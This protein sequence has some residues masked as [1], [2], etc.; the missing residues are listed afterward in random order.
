MPEQLPLS[1]YCPSVNL[2]S[3]IK[4]NP[5]AEASAKLVGVLYRNNAALAFGGRLFMKAKVIKC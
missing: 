3:L 5:Q 1:L 4:Y 2:S